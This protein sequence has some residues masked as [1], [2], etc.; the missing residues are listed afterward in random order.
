MKLQ[1]YLCVMTLAALVSAGCGGEKKQTAEV[2]KVGVPHLMSTYDHTKGFDGWSTTR[3][4]VG[5]TVVRF[6]ADG[7]LVPW[8][9]DFKDNVFTVKDVKFSDGSKLTAKDI[10]DSLTIPARR[11]PGLKM[12]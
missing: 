4:G 6:D 5:E 11:T 10:V 3:I 8:L 1:K 2:L 12:S 7:R 9:A